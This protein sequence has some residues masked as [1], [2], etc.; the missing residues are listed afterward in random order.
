MRSFTTFLLAMLATEISALPS[1]PKL[2]DTQ[3]DYYHIAKRQNE[4]AVALGLGDPDVLQFALTLEHLEEAFYKEATTK[5]P[6]AQSMGLEQFQFDA[7]AQIGAT[8]SAHVVLLQGALAQAG[9]AP[10]RPCE[11]D[12]SAALTD[13][14]TVLAT[15]SILENVGVAAYLG[16]ST[17]VAD[18]KI[19]SVAASILTIE[20]RHQSVL[21]VF[22]QAEP[23]PQA[24]DA[25]LG[26]RSVFSLAA[27]FIKSCPEGSN[28][29]VEAFPTLAMDEGQDIAA[30]HA[31]G[32]KV[33]VTS[34]A[35]GQAT[36]CAF[37]SGGVSTGG[38]IF[39]EFKEGEGCEIPKQVAGVSYMSL[40]TSAPLDGVV[41][42]DIMAAGPIAVTIT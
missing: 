39:S 24:F 28:L 12:F 40:V 6:D 1:A 32:A 37:T 36:H 16:A 30:L 21:R 26:L 25:A 5:F 19:L 27:P 13:P 10:V 3:L 29:V 20:A 17:I 23:V 22:T 34:E 41:T 35:A 18:A 31:S 2:S 8:E 11:Y 9:V 4:A 33:K 7:I 42:D 38:S 14:A 15:G